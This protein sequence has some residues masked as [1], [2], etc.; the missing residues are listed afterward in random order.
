LG[1]GGHEEQSC[2]PFRFVNVSTGYAEYEVYGG[3]LRVPLALPGLSRAAA[4]AA[5][6]WTIERMDARRGVLPI[7]HALGE[8]EVEQ[9]VTLRAFRREVGITLWFDDTGMFEIPGCGSP[10]RWSPGPDP[11]PAKLVQDILGRV[12]PVALYLDGAFALHGSAVAIDGKGIAFV[13]PKGYGKSTLA[14]ALL[15]R[16]ALLCADDV[17]LLRAG[18]PV[19]LHPGVQ[20]LRLA[21]ESR[22]RFGDT[23][24]PNL[25]RGVKRAVSPGS[26]RLQRGPVPLVAVYVLAPASGVGTEAVRRRAV[27]PAATMALLRESKLGPLLGGSEAAVMLGSA[28]R[29]AEG[30]PVWQLE[31]ARSWTSLEALVERIVAWHG[32]AAERRR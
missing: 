9:G 18:T 16:D 8:V 7:A 2:P 30:V 31:Y 10:I 14:R 26:E 29:V 20:S 27:G 23:D 25:D 11:D 24:Q 22:G 3:T 32:G 15:D 13:A 21:G 12:V 4:G 6:S 17:V 1:D 19:L 28:A 5:A